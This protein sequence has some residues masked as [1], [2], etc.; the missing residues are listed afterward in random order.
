MLAQRVAEEANEAKAN[1]LANMSHELRT[2]LT[3]I[4]GSSQLLE[5]TALSTEQPFM[6]NAYV[7]RAVS[8]NA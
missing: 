2:P 5:D 4:L 6:Y 1:F 8:S 7:R 3:T